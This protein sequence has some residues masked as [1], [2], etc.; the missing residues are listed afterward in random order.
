MI[1]VNDKCERIGNVFMISKANDF[2]SFVELFLHS[3]IASE[4]EKDNPWLFYKTPDEILE[5]YT[6]QCA[7]NGNKKSSIKISDEAKFWIG[8]MYAYLAIKHQI[9]MAQVQDDLP[10]EELYELFSLLHEIDYESAANR[11]FIDK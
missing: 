5:M 6:S 11:I 4:I 8:Y 1:D 2:F 10:P 9:S 3:S 7:S